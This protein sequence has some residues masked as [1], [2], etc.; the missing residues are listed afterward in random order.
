MH[1]RSYPC[2]TVLLEQHLQGVAMAEHPFAALL[3][4]IRFDAAIRQ[5]QDQIVKLK[6]EV[7]AHRAQEA[8][9]IDVLDAAK[10]AAIDA[11]KE[12]DAQE[13]NVRELAES[14]QQKKEK[15]DAVEDHKIYRALRAELEMV[16][17]K[18]QTAESALMNAINKH[19]AAQK[20]LKE[21]TAA[22]TARVTELHESIAT[23][24]KKIGELQ[25]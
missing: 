25:K 1:Q 6:D 17:R 21:K 23:A 19:D 4:L 16:Q 15:L 20:A 12:V 5:T 13:L 22:H 24:E 10:R 9:A 11:R 2:V 3:E 7:A 14:E 18:Q 8:D